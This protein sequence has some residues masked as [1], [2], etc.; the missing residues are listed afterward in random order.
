MTS[1]DASNAGADVRA[2]RD[3]PCPDCGASPRDATCPTCAK[4]LN[5]DDAA[6]QETVSTI[7]R[8]LGAVGWVAIA[9]AV[10]PALGGFLLLGSL[11]IVGPWL[12]SHELAGMALY[13]A[14]FALLAGFALLP[15]YAQAVLGGWAFGFWAG[16]PA[17]LL[18]F[19]GGSLIGYEVGR[20]SSGDRVMKILDQHPRWRLVRDALV[21][22][23]HG[24]GFARTLLIISLVRLPPN[25]PFALTNILL[26]SVRVP[27]IPYALGT[28]IGMAPRTGLAVYLA[29][30]I[31]GAIS[32]DAIPKPWWA[33]VATFGTTV[34]VFALLYAV[35]SRAIARVVASDRPSPSPDAA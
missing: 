4:A 29:S 12:K 24:A 3:V 7:F 13:V 2:D 19:F 26:S 33:W 9:A 8:K 11:D 28:L 6:P 10:L 1:N 15:T 20:R 31:K 5:P 18:G 21:G 17:A 16:F 35:A 27:R 14:A 30:E 22:G 34:L 25:S 32:K 23:E